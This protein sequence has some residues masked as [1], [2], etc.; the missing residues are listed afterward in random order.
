MKVRSPQLAEPA[1]MSRGGIPFVPGPVIPRVLTLHHQ[2]VA[3]HLRCNRRCRY[4]RTMCIR[5][6]PCHNRWNS[7]IGIGR[8]VKT[9]KKIRRV[10]KPI[11]A[12]IQNDDIGIETTSLC[13]LHGSTPRQPQGR[14]NSKTINLS[15]TGLPDFNA[16]TPLI[17]RLI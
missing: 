16:R 2:A 17:N 14:N 15:V 11:M 3:I 1:N 7:D 9:G 4:N 10:S 8:T 13:S 5:F 12:S 6:Y